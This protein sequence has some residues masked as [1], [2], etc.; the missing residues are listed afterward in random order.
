[1]SYGFNTIDL[2][3]SVH[4]DLALLFEQMQTC[5]HSLSD[6]IIEL[7]DGRHYYAHSWVLTF[8][9]CYFQRM[10]ESQL[11]ESQTRCIRIEDEPYLIEQ[12]LRYLYLGQVKFDNLQQLLCLC[13]TGKCMF[14]FTEFP[15]LH[16]AIYSITIIISR[17][18]FG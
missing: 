17:Q 5:S 1:M 9:S 8:R 2:Q 15:L 11:G 12:L 10:L 13:I 14:T 18:V 4:T 3:D 16:L 7:R 6:V